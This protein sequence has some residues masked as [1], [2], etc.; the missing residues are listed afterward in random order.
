MIV[1]SAVSPGPVPQPD[2]RA[3]GA[4]QRVAPQ[5]APAAAPEPS[6]QQ[7]RQAVEG[8]NRAVK[9]SNSNLEFTFDASTRKLVVRMVDADSGE[10]I[11]QIPSKVV[12]AIAESI[13][14]YQKGLLLSQKA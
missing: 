6:P 12:L 14:E 5:P 11:R 9:P 3:S 4:A 8:I 2:A 13:G 10:V 7:V 1:Q